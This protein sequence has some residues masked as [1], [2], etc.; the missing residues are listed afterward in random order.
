M[1][2]LKIK[3]KEN[4]LFFS[5]ITGEQHMNHHHIQVEPVDTLKRASSSTQNRKITPETTPMSNNVLSSSG[6]PLN[7]AYIERD[8]TGAQMLSAESTQAIVNNDTEST[9][10]QQKNQQ[11]NNKSSI[12]PSSSSPVTQELNNIWRKRRNKHPPTSNRRE[13]PNRQNGRIHRPSCR[14]KN[15]GEGSDSETTLTATQSK[16]EGM[17][18]NKQ[19]AN[20]RTNSFEFKET[21][22]IKFHYCVL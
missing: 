5:L 2:F 18:K 10:R 7:E 6:D 9:P 17:L 14:L 4:L 22:Q 8:N 12:T 3:R 13:S 20:H 1:S 11:E 21:P 16:N 19:T 15:Y